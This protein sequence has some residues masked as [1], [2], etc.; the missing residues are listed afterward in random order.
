MPE[1]KSVEYLKKNKLESYI[2]SGDHEKSVA[3]TSENLGIDKYYSELSP[4]EKLQ[5]IKRH[6]GKEMMIGDGINDSVALAASHVSVAMAG[7]IEKLLQTAD[8]V[9]LNNQ[10]KHIP[11]I[12]ALSNH[13]IKTLTWLSPFSISYNVVCAVP[14]LMGYITPLVA[15]LLMPMSSI[16]VIMFSFYRMKE[17]QWKLSM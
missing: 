16:L 15:A 7:P 13:I 9:L 5:M 4:E 12:F 6:A 14:A 17:G 8:I 2:I 11:Q 3:F 1:K 10:I